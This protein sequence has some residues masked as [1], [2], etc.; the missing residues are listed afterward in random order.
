MDGPLMDEDSLTP[1]VP[2]VV[3]HGTPTVQAKE[4]SCINTGRLARRARAARKTGWAPK[5]LAKE[6]HPLQTTPS[7]CLHAHSPTDLE[8]D[9]SRVLCSLLAGSSKLVTGR[10]YHC[11]SLKRRRNGLATVPP[12]SGVYL[13]KS[14]LRVSVHTQSP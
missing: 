2:K 3:P 11:P 1:V 9:C 6:L 8:K 14:L 13:S 7:K 12:F 10:G 5:S 4:M